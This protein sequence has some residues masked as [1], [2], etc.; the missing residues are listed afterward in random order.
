MQEVKGSVL[1]SRFAMVED[2]GGGPE[3]VERVLAAMSPDD[4]A[5]LKAV[6]AVGWYPFDLGTRLDDAIVKTLGGGRTEFFEKLGRASAD[7]NLAG[8][9]KSFL[10][11]G[12]PHRFLSRAHA[13]YAAYYKTGHREYERTGE[14]EAVLTTFEA[15]AFSVP[16]CLTVVGWH[17]K[18]LEM[19][20][21]SDVNVVEEECR[22]RGGAVCRYR[23]KWG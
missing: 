10:A 14:K 8:P 21:C 23:V 19:C 22:A 12:D 20:G 6:V 7:K 9:H 15:D 13:I 1:K 11:P 18:A 16:D 17:K 2:M 5:A 4:R 3:A